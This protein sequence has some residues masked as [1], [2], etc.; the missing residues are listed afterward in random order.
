MRLHL[1]WSYRWGASVISHWQQADAIG[2]GE[3]EQGKRAW[4]ASA[5]IQVRGFCFKMSQS[6]L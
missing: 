4:Q 1:K 2:E 3:G 5:L 6:I